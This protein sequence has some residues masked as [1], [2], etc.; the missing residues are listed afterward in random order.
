MLLGTK[1]EGTAPSHGTSLLLLR[2]TRSP[3]APSPSP[4]TPRRLEVPPGPGASGILES[5][6]EDCRW[7][8]NVPWREV[9]ADNFPG[10]VLLILML[11][12]MAK[13]Q[14]LTSQRLRATLDGASLS[15]RLSELAKHRPR[16][17]A[18]ALTSPVAVG[19]TPTPN[20]HGKV[21]FAVSTG[22]CVVSDLPI[23]QYLLQN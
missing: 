1:Y 13:Q 4:N 16:K 9:A 14:Q 10:A 20:A 2:S 18:S 22:L 15:W 3:R 17:R 21:V 8:A 7:L 5:F 19:G 12:C 23:E 6:S 11:R